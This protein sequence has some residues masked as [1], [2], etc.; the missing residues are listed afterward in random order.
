MFDLV[1]QVLMLVETLTRFRL[2]RIS[3][4]RCTFKIVSRVNPIEERCLELS[5]LRYMQLIWRFAV[6][7]QHAM[8]NENP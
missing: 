6:H 4:F 7:D 3:P 8:H 1:E 2:T 5:I